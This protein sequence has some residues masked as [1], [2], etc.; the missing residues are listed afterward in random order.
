MIEMNIFIQKAIRNKLKQPKR[1][2]KMYNFIER[3]YLHSNQDS[4]SFWQCTFYNRNPNILLKATSC[5][6]FRAPELKQRFDLSGV[7]A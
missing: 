6:S 1:N 5:A 2:N 4:K 7:Y 3:Y